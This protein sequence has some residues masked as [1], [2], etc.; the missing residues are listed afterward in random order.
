MPIDA[1]PADAGCVEHADHAEPRVVGQHSIQPLQRAVRRAVIDHDE[2]VVDR[3]RFQS[4][5][6][7]GHEP[8]HVVLL[9]VGGGHDRK[10]DRPS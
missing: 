2:L 6:D 4:R 8:V 7:L 5:A 9:V 3:R 10:R 1:P